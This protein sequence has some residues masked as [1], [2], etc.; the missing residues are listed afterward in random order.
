VLKKLW[1]KHFDGR[2]FGNPGRLSGNDTTKIK[3][4]KPFEMDEG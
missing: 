4:L 3:G 1:G 2:T